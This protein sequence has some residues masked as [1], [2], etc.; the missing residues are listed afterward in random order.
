MLGSRSDKADM[1]NAAFMCSAN[2]NNGL[3]QL[4][5]AGRVGRLSSWLNSHSVFAVGFGCHSDTVG[6]AIEGLQVT[7]ILS[8]ESRAETKQSTLC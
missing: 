7:G 6:F 5:L 4:G 1:R 2:T 3:C 8:V